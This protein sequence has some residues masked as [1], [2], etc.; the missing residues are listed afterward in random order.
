MQS[1]AFGSLG[2][3]HHNKSILTVFYNTSGGDGGDVT[4]A[5]EWLPG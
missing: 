3:S 4:A 1:G 2:F 5:G